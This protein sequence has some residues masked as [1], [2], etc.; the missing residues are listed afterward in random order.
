MKQNTKKIDTTQFYTTIFSYTFSK[1][2]TSAKGYEQY[3]VI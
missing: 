2:T 1:N 3:Q